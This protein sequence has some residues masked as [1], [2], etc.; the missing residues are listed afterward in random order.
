MGIRLTVAW[1]ESSEELK[2]RYH[3]DTLSARGK[4]PSAQSRRGPD[5]AKARCWL[6]LGPIVV[7][8]DISAGLGPAHRGVGARALHVPQGDPQ[9]AKKQA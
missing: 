4:E 5:S 8:L 6:G 3:Y 7:A 1:Q 2:H 9:A